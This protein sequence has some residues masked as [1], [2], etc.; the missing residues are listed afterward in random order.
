MHLAPVYAVPTLAH[1]QT[2]I[3][4]TF[5]VAAQRVEETDQV[6]VEHRAQLTKTNVND[7]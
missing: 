4:L 7:S 2:K 5:R 3:R 6:T 1:F